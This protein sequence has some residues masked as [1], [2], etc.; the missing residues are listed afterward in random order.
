MGNSFPKLVFSDRKQVSH[1][2]EVGNSFPEELVFSD[3]KQVSQ[4]SYH[5]VVSQAGFCSKAQFQLLLLEIDE[6]KDKITRQLE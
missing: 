2:L 3:G 6:I 5:K 1:L 4:A